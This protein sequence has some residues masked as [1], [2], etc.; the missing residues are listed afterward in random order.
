MPIDKAA[1]DA[2]L[3]TIT[4]SADS[5]NR[6]VS[7]AVMLLVEDALQSLRRIASTLEI[8]ATKSH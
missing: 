2:A 3:K 1:I 4:E 5:E 8:I 7:T 6:E